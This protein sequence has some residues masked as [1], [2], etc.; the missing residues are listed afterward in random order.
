MLW[1]K[2]LT[3]PLRTQFKTLLKKL[4]WTLLK[5]DAIDNTIADAIANAIQDTVDDAIDGAIGDAMEDAIEDA[6]GG[7]Y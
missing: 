5:M 6:S 2:L 1:T 7:R 3:M 4:F